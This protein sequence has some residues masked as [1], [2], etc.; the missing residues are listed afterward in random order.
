MSEIYITGTGQKLKVHDEIKCKLRH[1]VIHNPSNHHMRDWPT[2][3]RHD[4][5]IMERICE[6]GIGHPDP[7][8]LAYRKSLDPK[9]TSLG[10]HGCDGCCVPPKRKILYHQ[11][12][13][14]CSCV[15]GQKGAI[16]TNEAL[17]YVMSKN[18]VIGLRCPNCGFEWEIVPNK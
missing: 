2:H 10:V 15:E 9:D 11:N 6:H 3:W 4:L 5:Q 14:Y 7:D 16:E 17:S 13:L 12:K 8:S 18:G 1:C